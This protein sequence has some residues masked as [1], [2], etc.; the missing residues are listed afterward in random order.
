MLMTNNHSSVC[1]PV[2]N[3]RHPHPGN[4]RMI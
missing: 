1:S 3:L 4:M 2:M